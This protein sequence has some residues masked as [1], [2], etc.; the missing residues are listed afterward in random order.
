MSELG[1]ERI[2]LLE[3]KSMKVPFDYFLIDD[4]HFVFY[5]INQFSS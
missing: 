5:L 3:I 2:F 1:G 4:I